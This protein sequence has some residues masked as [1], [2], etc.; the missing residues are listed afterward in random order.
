MT[1]ELRQW[2]IKDEKKA[3]VVNVLTK[4]MEIFVRG[5]WQFPYL[6]TVPL[7]TVLSAVFLFHMVS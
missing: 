1:C 7:N 2:Q 3:Q 4:D 6:F 5:S